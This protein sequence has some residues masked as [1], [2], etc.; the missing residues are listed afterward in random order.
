MFALGHLSPVQMIHQFLLGIILSYLVYAT[1]PVWYSVAIHF[2]NNAGALF[3]EM[4]PGYAEALNFDGRGAWLLPVLCVA[5]IIILY[6]SLHA[7]V[8]LHTGKGYD[9]KD[10]FCAVIT[11]RGEKKWYAPFADDA[12]CADARRSDRAETLYVW[13]IIVFLAVLTA[14][15]TVLSVKGVGL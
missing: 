7:L 1:G 15:N 2:L 9:R 13:M 11:G 10:G 8:K 4:I 12:F 6:P 5:G 14:I 3:A